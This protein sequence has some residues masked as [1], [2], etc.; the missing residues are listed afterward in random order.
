MESKLE[1]GIQQSA[2]VA[3]LF[4]ETCQSSDERQSTL[5]IRLRCSSDGVDLSNRACSRGK[6]PKES[7]SFIWDRMSNYV[8]SGFPPYLNYA[9]YLT[10]ASGSCLKVSASL[11][12]GSRKLVRK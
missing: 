8:F 5:L 1:L 4:L 7:M 10:R 6:F 11:P 2:E 3:G 9:L 12:P